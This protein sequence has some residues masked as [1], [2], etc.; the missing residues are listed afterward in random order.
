MKMYVD[1]QKKEIGYRIGNKEGEER[2][3][4]DWLY[5]A[6]TKGG[7]VVTDDQAIVNDNQ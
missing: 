5:I 3:R 1:K 2:E 4:A 6:T 7:E